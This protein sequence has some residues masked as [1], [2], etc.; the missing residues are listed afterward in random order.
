MFE[1]FQILK[2]AL[3]RGKRAKTLKNGKRNLI[4][5]LFMHF[6][7][8]GQNFINNNYLFY[9]K[10]FEFEEFCGSIQPQHTVNRV[11]H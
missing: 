8:E 5:F 3:K 2:K 1:K 10:S 11:L 4:F 6:Y 9:A 7:L